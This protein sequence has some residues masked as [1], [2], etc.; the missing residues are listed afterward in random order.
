MLRLEKLTGFGNVRMVEADLPKP[1]EGEALV[2]VHRSLIS[3]GSELFRRY[4]LEEPVPPFMMGYSDAGEV[5][6]PGTGLEDVKPG[7]RVFVGGPHAQYVTGQPRALPDSISYDRAPFIALSTS[8]V[9]WARTTPVEPGDDVVVLGQGIVGNL[10]S[11]AVRERLPGRVITVDTLS[12]RLDASRQSGADVVVDASSTDPVQEVFGLTG[13]R[14]ADVVVDCVGGPA[15]VESFAQAQRMLKPDGV[16]HLIAAYQGGPRPGAGLLPLD[17]KHHDGQDCLVSG[18]RT[19]EP[20]TYHQDSAVQM[21]DD[22]RI[23][24]DHLVDTSS[25]LAADPGR[26]PPAL[27][28]A[29]PGLG[30]APGVGMNAQSHIWPGEFSGKCSVWPPVA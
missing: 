9:A 18:I 8:A 16:I 1:G 30:R 10:Y 14:G 21:I 3:R 17:S 5:V 29:R 26:L 13:G 7:D 25:T 19:V 6:E 27:Q 24:V 12:L 20:R 15:G 4:V 2:R 23:A 22:E 28:Q 11:Q